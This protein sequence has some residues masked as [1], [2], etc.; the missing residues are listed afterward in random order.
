[1]KTL[2]IRFLLYAV[3]ACAFACARNKPEIKVDHSKIRHILDSA[4]L[5]FDP[6]FYKEK[7]VAAVYEIV[8]SAI[9]PNSLSII[10]KIGKMPTEFYPGSF[11]VIYKDSLDNVLG[12]YKMWSPFY[13]RVESQ[14]PGIGIRKVYTG[15]FQVPLPR[16][17]RVAVVLMR[18]GPDGHY[19]ISNV[20]LLFKHF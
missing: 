17:P 14:G 19:T 13:Q 5:P 2:T 1:M 8:D 3:I 6:A 9:S 11:E 20:K 4:T 12:S 16:D 15:K 10:E 18:D 7:H